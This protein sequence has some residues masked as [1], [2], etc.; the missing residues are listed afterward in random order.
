M[1][2]RRVHIRAAHDRPAPRLLALAERTPRAADIVAGAPPQPETCGSG[3]V[4]ATT[5]QPFPRSIAT[6][7]PPAVPEDRPPTSRLDAWSRA[8]Q[9]AAPSPVAAEPGSPARR[10]DATPPR[11]AVPPAGLAWIHREPAIPPA[12]P[13]FESIAAPGGASPS[14]ESQEPGFAARTAKGPARPERNSA[15]ALAPPATGLGP[16]PGYRAPH[17]P[18]EAPRM[19][20]RPATSPVQALDPLAPCTLAARMPVGPVAAATSSRL[21]GARPA[22]L[23]SLPDEWVSAIEIPEEIS[24]VPVE[25]GVPP[26]R[27]RFQVRLR[28]QDFPALPVRTPVAC[29]FSRPP[30]DMVHHR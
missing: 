30:Q 28:A 5:P 1:P 16:L 23:L 10:Q 9:V 4:A 24:V 3:S 26:L 27:P 19:P 18:E 17:A 21:A 29:A 2:G 22:A 14:I 12:P 8:R 25:A 11:T 13:V 7:A 20:L 6:E 15:I